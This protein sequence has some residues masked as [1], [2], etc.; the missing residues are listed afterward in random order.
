[1][2]YNIVKESGQIKLIVQLAPY[3][4]KGETWREQFTS[5]DAHSIIKEENYIGYNLLSKPPQDL[6][7]K[8]TSPQG[9]YIFVKEKKASKPLV[10]KSVDTEPKPVL[11]SS[12]RRKKSSLEKSTGE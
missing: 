12:K 3:R 9:V 6:D 1:M 10:N 4:S 8:F 7:N 2:K 5:Q 11:Q